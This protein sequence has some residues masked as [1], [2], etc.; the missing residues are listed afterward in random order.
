MSWSNT[1]LCWTGEANAQTL[2]TQTRQC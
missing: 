2:A 1:A